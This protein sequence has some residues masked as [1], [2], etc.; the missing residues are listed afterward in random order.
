MRLSLKHIYLF[1]NF[2][3]IIDF[4]LIVSHVY[5]CFVCSGSKRESDNS[6][7]DT[8]EKDCKKEHSAID[9][10]QGKCCSDPYKVSFEIK[11][12]RQ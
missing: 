8:E 3:F 7:P 10:Y 11:K 2:S 6:F 1:G 9:S 5:V 4:K 12:K